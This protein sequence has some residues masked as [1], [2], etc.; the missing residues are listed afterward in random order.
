VRHAYPSVA[1]TAR[2][3]RSGCA[4]VPPNLQ[5]WPRVWRHLNLVDHGL[6]SGSR[7]RGER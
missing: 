3:A 5:V 6:K 4:L 7:Y 2:S 1:S